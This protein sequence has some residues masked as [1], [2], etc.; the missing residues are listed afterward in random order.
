MA[1][2]YDFSTNLILS[3]VRLLIP[4][5]VNTPAQPAIFTDD[6]IN[7]FINLESSQG[8]YVSGQAAPTGSS[9]TVLPI[10]YSVR[11]AAALAL[12]VIA[13]KLA[14]LA[15]ISVLDVKLELQNASKAASDRAQSLRDE[16]ARMGNFAI[17]EMVPTA[18][19]A[20]ERIWSQLLRIEGN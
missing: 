17:A 2:T 8:L 13:S 12:D 7:Q 10:I 4:D 14:R 15:G 1:F 19:A 16:E 9:V 18:F 3:Q 20:R 5:T 6:E 11:R